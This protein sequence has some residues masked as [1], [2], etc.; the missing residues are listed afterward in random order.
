MK[1]FLYCIFFILLSISQCYATP[2]AEVAGDGV[3]DSLFTGG[4]ASGTIGACPA[5]FMDAVY[6]IDLVTPPAGCDR[7]C[8][9]PDED[10]DGYNAPVA[11]VCTVGTAGSTN[12]DSNDH[13]R[14]EIPL[15]YYP[16][17]AGGGANSGYHQALANGSYSACIANSVTPLAEASGGGVN[18]Y[19]D[20]AAG[21]DANPGTYA[22]PYLT[23][24]PT[25]SV[26]S[27]SFVYLKAGTCTAGANYSS[28]GP[29][30]L[31]NNITIEGYPGGTGAFNLVNTGGFEAGSNFTII[32]LSFTGVCN[33][34]GANMTPVHQLAI[35]GFEARRNVFEH[36]TM[37]TFNNNSAIY[38]NGTNT[39]NT[40]HN[41]FYDWS[42]GT[43]GC[44]NPGSGQNVHGMHW[45][46]DPP[47][48]ADHITQFNVFIQPLP[49]DAT[50]SGSDVRFKHGV[51]LVN[52]GPN[53]V[54][55]HHNLQISPPGSGI[56]PSIDYN[57]SGLRYHHNFSLN[58]GPF[59]GQSGGTEPNQDNQIYNNTG[60]GKMVG[61]VPNYQTVT[62]KL[63][64]HDNVVY[65]PAASY[66]PGNHEGIVDIDG[67]G[68]STEEAQLRTNNGGTG[69]LFFYN[70]C[71]YNPNV[72]PNFSYFSVPAGGGG[73]G[74]A[75]SAGGNYNFTQWKANTGPIAN[76][77]PTPTP[78]P[79]GA[80][81]QTDIVGSFVVD[82][83]LNLFNQATNPNC[84]DKGAF[85]LATPTP[86]PVGAVAAIVHAKGFRVG[87]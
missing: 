87:R 70:N 58:K 84:M 63:T 7:K 66:N 3:D 44:N 12:C 80:P 41:L 53:G 34:A 77:A 25:T 27:G 40:H 71:Y 14:R 32:A 10:C 2:A 81:Q 35:N 39:S 37:S 31:K 29:S 85:P 57:G 22:S 78:Y 68:S 55:V 17:D 67:Y 45:L 18:K 20:C 76:P 21:N 1:Q 64:V 36:M 9:A 11:G 61:W 51:A 59:I 16:C 19:V 69:S 72:A 4:V 49:Y 24:A 74:P 73:H 6:G 83:A 65:D 46:N 54:Q 33:G 15:D 82:P 30:G 56:Q 75:D 38:L 42:Q 60:I 79:V 23:F 13:D 28:T 47:N 43:G 52:T 48:G 5:G 50:Q 8:P 62:D 86:V 26:P